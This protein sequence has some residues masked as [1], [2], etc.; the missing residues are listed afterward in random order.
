MQHMILM[1]KKMRSQ[2]KF[3]E[4]ELV[5]YQTPSVSLP[6]SPPVPASLTDLNH[7]TWSVHA[8][9]A[10][11]GPCIHSSAKRTLYI[12]RKHPSNHLNI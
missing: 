7:P 4:I 11:R 3:Y 8:A 5:P 6:R 9:R 1:S 12:C 10:K 2:N